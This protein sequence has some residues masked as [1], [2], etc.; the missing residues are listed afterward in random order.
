[1][2]PTA[3]SWE[4]VLHGAALGGISETAVWCSLGRGAFLE[5]AGATAEELLASVLTVK[6]KIPESWLK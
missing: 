3:G 4:A 6:S 1:M 2:Q 5:Q